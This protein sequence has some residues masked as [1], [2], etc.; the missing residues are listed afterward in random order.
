MTDAT[1]AMLD[2]AARLALR[3][4]G[5]A[6]P[7]PV[8]GCVIV[9]PDG[10]IVGE[11]FHRRCGDAHAERVA[12]TRAGAAARGA[13]VYVTL[14]PCA[15]TG[16]TGPCAAALVEAGVAR[17]VVGMADPNPAAAGGAS[18]LRAAGI[19]VE[20]LDAS[21]PRAA[22]SRAI[23]APFVHRLATGLPW[24][25][26]KW[27]QTVD[28]R[29]ATRTGLSRWISG[30]RSRRM[31]HRERGRVDVIMTGI[32]T[33]LADDPQLTARSVRR[34][35]TARRVVI[36]PK[37]QTPLDAAL[38]R[39]AGDVPTSIACAAS[40][41]AARPERV[42]ALESAGVELIAIPMDEDAGLPLAPVL[43]H[44]VTAHDATHVL[45]DAGAGLLGRLFA[46]RLVHAAWV[47]IA[48]LLLGDERAIPCVRG[49]TSE[50]LTD[51]VP[52]AL[53]W[54]RRR[55]DDVVLGYGVGVRP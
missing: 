55:D 37:L 36:D 12:L 5:G 25:T 1:G 51:G 48:P 13:T 45:V 29:I 43:R 42:I 26:V 8:V 44:L 11:G 23:A 19:A 30:P 38:V 32:G 46:E 41:L 21:D 6:E 35:R 53:Q 17:V 24:V 22:S 52:L 31:V 49:L 20:M 28:G 47:F 9:A 34:R 15:H 27:A 7:N 10:R 14:E 54:I 3:G 33:V 2:R 16:R 4:H 40:I 50:R 18:T 39:T